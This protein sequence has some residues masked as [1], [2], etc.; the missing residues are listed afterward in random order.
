MVAEGEDVLAAALD[1]GVTPTA[2]LFDEAHLAADD[3]LVAATAGLAERYAVPADLLARASTLAVPPRVLAV[4]PQPAPPSFGDVAFP[5]QPALWLT[6][7]ADPGNVGTLIRTAAALGADWLAL[8]PGSADPFHPR[9]VRAAM[10]ATFA[11][12]L[13]QRVSPEHLATRQG[14]TVVAGVPAG[15][16]PPWEVDLAVPA[17]I[18]LGAEREGVEPALA[19]FGDRP[20]VRVTIP[21]RPGAESLN[22]AAAGAALLAEASRQRAVRAG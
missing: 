20:V 13:L 17:V 7:V 1:R 16:E 21:Q 10:G 22:V 18:V 9:A 5:P 11:L 6:G 15:G 4:L 19:A 8:G 14:F 3:P 12:P 2:V